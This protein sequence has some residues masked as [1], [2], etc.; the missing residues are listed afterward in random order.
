MLPNESRGQSLYCFAQDGKLVQHRRLSQFVFREFR[1]T[2]VLGE[3]DNEARRIRNLNQCY[4]IPIHKL[5]LRSPEWF[6][7]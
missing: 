4:P 1:K 3:I 5:L 7:L 6:A 2:K